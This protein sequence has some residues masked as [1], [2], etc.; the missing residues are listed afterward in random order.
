MHKFDITDGLDWFED[1]PD[2]WLPHFTRIDL[3]LDL[4]DQ[5]HPH[6]GSHD[7]DYSAQLTS[8]LNLCSGLKELY[9]YFPSVSDRNID[10]LVESFREMPAIKNLSKL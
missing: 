3:I 10:K 2:R 8:R 9:I 4:D 1:L 7:K 6:Y 5:F